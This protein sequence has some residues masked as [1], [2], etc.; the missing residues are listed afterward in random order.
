MFKGYKV[1]GLCI[2]K[3]GDEG[4]FNFIKS[5]NDEISKKGYR[6]FI[7]QSSADMYLGS[8]TDDGD[9]AIYGA[10]PFHIL[11]AVVV[12][13]DSF[14]DKGIVAGIVNKAHS[15]GVPVLIFGRSVKGDCN[16]EYDSMP[17]FEKL[18]RHVIE[19]HG[20]KDS[21]FVAGMK[22][23]FNSEQRLAVYKKVLE[24]NNIPFEQSRVYYGN[25]WSKPAEAAAYKIIARDKLPGAVIYANDVMAIAVCGIF[26]E[27]NIKVPDDIIVTGF[28]GIIGAYGSIPAIT[29]CAENQGDMACRI[30]SSIEKLWNGEQI[31]VSVKAKCDFDILQSCGCKPTKKLFNPARVLLEYQEGLTKFQGDE[32]NIYEMSEQLYLCNNA[33][34]FKLFLYT[35]H[36]DNM[37]L[38]L[39]ESCFDESLNPA[40]YRHT[41]KYD[42][43]LLNVYSTDKPVDKYP[44]KFDMNDIVPD[45]DEIMKRG[46]PVVFSSLSFYGQTAGIP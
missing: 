26:D 13:D 8:S 20:V 6:L 34:D 21:C 16:F 28:D 37:S 4:Y 9:K 44:K 43:F 15:N 38:L 14:K 17:A 41:G 36:F 45:G 40:T 39:N 19:F 31:P 29:T 23:E 10:I 5:F 33:N 24:E 35:C 1:I 30:L 27:N 3:V 22:G 7:Y 42:R 11:D 32:R 46:F 25:Y 18:I 12:W 2:T